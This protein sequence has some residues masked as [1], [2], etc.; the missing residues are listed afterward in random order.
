MI[1]RLSLIFLLTQAMLFGARSATAETLG[2]YSGGGNLA[3][4]V[5]PNGYYNIR[6]AAYAGFR[7]AVSEFT[8]G[9]VYRVQVKHHGGSWANVGNITN[10]AGTAFGF[11][12]SQ[13][14]V[15]A[16][17][18]I[19]IASGSQLYF[20]VSD[21]NGSVE[22][23]GTVAAVVTGGYGGNNAFYVDITR[24]T[25]TAR[26]DQYVKENQSS[27]TI[28]GVGY[29]TP[30]DAPSITIGGTAITA[31]SY[32]SDTQITLTIPA[33]DFG[34]DII[35]TDKALNTTS[36]GGL[37]MV[38]DNTAPTVTS[39]TP[40]TSLKSGGTTEIDGSGFLETTT[41]S[42][43]ASVTLGG[44]TTGIA[45]YN[46]D[47]NTGITVTATTGNVAYGFLT[48]TDASGNASSNQ[49]NAKIAIDN[50]APT[51]A[52]VKNAAGVN[53]TV[54]SAETNFN[55]VLLT[56]GS[57]ANEFNLANVAGNPVVTIGDK[58]LTEL[59]VTATY[60]DALITL[61]IGAT[62]TDIAD[63]PVKV[64]DVALNE[65]TA[66]VNF[67]IDRVKPTV[68]SIG[69]RYV[70][71]SVATVVNGTGF[72]TNGNATALSLGG[73]PIS[74]S[75]EGSWTPNS[76]TQ[77]T[78]TPNTT[79]FT[80]ANVTVTD[81]AG[82][83]S[84][85]T[86]KLVTVDNT[87]PVISQIDDNSAPYI[88][89]SGTQFQIKYTGSTAAERYTGGS[90]TSA[91]SGD[92]QIRINNAWPTGMTA[93]VATNAIT[94]TAGAGE[95]NGA[96]KIFDRSGN[97]VE[98]AGP[99]I[100]D[101][102]S[103]TVTDVTPDN[104]TGNGGADDD[105][106]HIKTGG[107]ITITGSDFQNG[108]ANSDVT[109]KLAS[110]NWT[111]Y[112]TVTVDNDGQITLANAEGGTASG[113]LVITDLAG[114]EL[115]AA[116]WTV[117]VDNTLP[118]VTK[119]E[120][121]AIIGGET[122][123]V[124]GTGFM[125]GAA[126][127]TV[128]VGGSNAASTTFTYVVDSN[129]Q[130]TITGGTGNIDDGQIIVTD[131]ATNASTSNVKMTID[132][133][134]P[135]VTE[136]ATASIKN[137][138]T[139]VI[140]GT[141]FRTT[142]DGAFESTGTA[143]TGAE[144]GTDIAVRVGG[145][146]PAG[147]TFKVNSATQITVTAGP[148]EAVEKLDV[149]VT[150]RAGNTSVETGKILTIDNTR[151][152]LANVSAISIKSSGTTVLTGE[153]FLVGGDLPANAVKIDGATPTGM[154]YGTVTSTSLVITAGAGNAEDKLITV[155]DAAGNVSQ[156]LVYL[157]IDNNLPTVNSVGTAAIR[158]GV[159]SV[160]GGNG[161]LNSTPNSD[162][163][164]DIQAVK[165]GE[166][167]ITGLTWATNSNTQ[168]TF[169]AGA[170]EV[171]NA[172]ITVR[173]F[174][175]NWSTSTGQNITIDNTPPVLTN[176]SDRWIRNGET[177]IITGS[178][179]K[180]FGGDA[181]AILI[182]GLDLA[183]AVNAGGLG[184][185][186]VVDSDTKITVTGGLGNVTRGVVHV[187]D[188]VGNWSDSIKELSIDNVAPA[189]PS[190]NYL[191]YS[192]S[193]TDGD[194]ISSDNNPWWYV[195]GVSIGDSIIVRFNK[196]GLVTDGVWLARPS[197]TSGT[198][199][200][201]WQERTAATMRRE[202]GTDYEDALMIQNGAPPLLTENGEYTLTA[203]AID[204]AGNESPASE[205]SIYDFDN[206]DP[207]IPVIDKITAETNTGEN[208]IDWVTSS[209]RPEFV[210]SNV[211]IGHRIALY[212]NDPDDDKS[213]KYLTL[214]D[215]TVR[216]VPDTIKVAEDLTHD[217]A[218]R[219]A[220]GVLF[221]EFRIDWS[222]RPVVYDIANNDAWAADQIIE[223]DQQ[224]D[225]AKIT[226]A[227]ITSGA[228]RNAVKSLDNAVDITVKFNDNMYSN[229]DK[230]SLNIYWP[231]DTD[232]PT[233]TNAEM[234]I[235]E[236]D[237]IWTYRLTLN[238]ED[239]K[240]QT[241]NVRV[242]PVAR[243]I[244]GNYID[245]VRIVDT[246]KLF[247]DNTPPDSSHMGT[248]TAGSR[249]DPPITIPV[250]W[251]SDDT[252]SLK[253]FL[254]LSSTD[255]TLLRGGEVKIE[256]SIRAK[257]GDT[258]RTV[259]NKDGDAVD[260]I[261]TVG[262]AVPF[263]RLEA[264]IL[265]SLEGTLNA[266]DTMSFRATV[267]DRSGNSTSGDPSTS[268]F[269][270]D[271]IPPVKPL[272]TNTFI[273]DTLFTQGAVANI[274]TVNRDTLWANDTIR[275]AFKSFQDKGLVTSD[276]VSGMSKYEYSLYQSTKLTP[277]DNN[278][279]DWTKFR[280]FRSK[281][282]VGG[283]LL[284]TTRT[285]T[286]AL[287]H[288]RKYYIAM[289]G[290]D[291]A[292]NASDTVNSFRTLRFSTRPYIAPLADTTAKED[293]LFEM[294]TLVNDNDALTLRGD[295]FTYGLTTIKI[296]TTKSPIDS[297]V[298]TNLT[299]DISNAGKLTFTPTK[300][301]TGY[302][303][304]RVIATDDWPLTAETRWENK[305]T[306]D[307]NI[308]VVP[309]NDA[310]KIDLSSIS[311]LEF[312]E[313]A[314]SDSINLTRYSYDEDNDTT[315][316]KF[317]FRIAS[318]MPSKGGFPTAK[319]GFL[320][321]FNAEYK[322]S[323]ISKLVDEFPSST[324]IQKNN[325][326]V[327]YPPNVEK[328][329]DPIKVYS[330]EKSDSVYSWIM[331]TDTASNDTNYYTS[332]DMIVEFTVTDPG[333]LTDEDTV[334]FFI[335]PINDPPVW[336]GLRDTIVKENDSLYID[337]ANYLTDV[338]DSTVTFSILPLTYDA[339]VTV[340]PT[341]TFEKKATGYVYSSD[342]RKDTVKF[343][344]SALWFD[345][346]SG[347]WNPIDPLSNQIKFQVS[348]ADGDTSAIDTFILR[349]QRVPRPEIRM[350]VVQNNAFTNYY[351]IF[352]V[353]SVGKTKDIALK[354]QSK[355]VTLDTAAA[356]TYVG[357]YNFKTKGT[358]TFEVEANGIVGDT[359]ITQNLGL[360]LAK[361]YGRWSG[362]S[363]DGQ[364]N[365][366]GQNGAVDF[367]QSIIIMDS[368]LFEP[369]FSDRASYLLGNEAFRF[370]KS[371]EISMPGQDNEMALYQRSTGTG[372]IELPSITQG[373]RIMAYTEK[374]G[375]F[376][377]GPKTLIVPGETALQ[378]NYPNPFNPVTTIAYDLGFI[379]GPFQ[380]VN[381]TV[382]DIL[383]R[384]VKTLINEQQGIGRYRVKWNGKDQN[385]VPV[386]SGIYFVHLLTDM[387]RSQTKKIMLM[388]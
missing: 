347:P 146:I 220:N 258:W 314:S 190:K 117:Y 18:G 20:Q 206:I 210:I 64:V 224:G 312:L 325:A 236:N 87:D 69:T 44:A 110:T 24:P 336:A 292:G 153:G 271:T 163:V 375:Y 141:G 363:A 378:Q 235:G 202:A 386:A 230:P 306:L 380:R 21:Y 222:Y 33:G 366:T 2:R 291:I 145:N 73:E 125:N 209:K 288:E 58:S 321:D 178:G 255:T 348:A 155:E 177:T 308:N 67:T 147:M 26:S 57:G 55:K 352:L 81:V 346:N 196:T 104:D 168:L 65:V 129:T 349:V 45:G 274:L 295:K 14:D 377:M 373:N 135:T 316:L 7:I 327:I 76:D 25:V 330:L 123:V 237:S 211:T 256:A 384:N 113:N 285:D 326:F 379:D 82:N 112:G 319:T 169:T 324:I 122:A 91:S 278:P 164:I 257:L 105:L 77:I 287:T 161:F 344:P 13:S 49:N 180:E 289:R 254:P 100:I 92:L 356:F 294:L 12:L 185:S 41:A 317:S 342:A 93:S 263:Y 338:D 266:G 101:N 80:D 223:I 371:V 361:M 166:N 150:D 201:D 158:S 279:A 262:V 83:T 194:Q 179:F 362:R 46:V 10:N 167:V 149:T 181:S 331:P 9:G 19:T 219:R 171:T 32:D 243:D 195:A 115:T 121:G 127:S 221:D 240:K 1:L 99:V 218:K 283:D 241:G 357:H 30:A 134:K 86:G 188:F 242:V 109:I 183:V 157:T 189:A 249:K 144:A 368:T 8:A 276:R 251:F 74:T 4:S 184:G 175:G 225:T 70:K 376:R 172:N 364:F 192:D 182:G 34:G 37:A 152:T 71:G 28:T 39:S 111:T 29:T 358:Y 299:A 88:F 284:D 174:A 253:F 50:T 382:Y 36:A 197:T 143:F 282:N 6:A 244:A 333:G 217:P 40:K 365:V 313:G 264:D 60:A 302:Y 208:S 381:M 75:G 343:K 78:F 43:I 307:L 269:V 229:P 120:P 216:T 138:S 84:A 52:S 309:V 108:V 213:G 275:F 53:I 370:K 119:V 66:G 273:R 372:W 233:I 140:T 212:S 27:V 267:Y 160:I 335:D 114:N 351:E 248:I 303:A 23:Q 350:Y 281:G 62:G 247:L 339:N 265:K 22:L 98:A 31:A 193:G 322:K 56:S 54:G 245:A 130:I 142:V 126:K 238:D 90:G 159:T 154:T 246:L 128:T 11:N 198:N 231:N 5:I 301:D 232:T 132:N 47:S 227:D 186:F 173:D 286:F 203:F 310:P 124:T 35:V 17:S 205:A 15:E 61:T 383:G 131:P 96:V 176:I 148:G 156:S 354:V 187:K 300:I 199:Q 89:K 360:A 165:L 334:T 290:V 340:E 214:D 318:T 59:G 16:A 250:G 311:K 103:P 387:G 3:A 293:I 332:Y 68:T 95:T 298:V 162:A 268:V 341:K 139:T 388:R 277:D 102:T 252:D 296:D 323:F 191:A 270:L 79:E 239:V 328:L 51:V 367:D 116:T 85:E 315:D 337:F 207:A 374:M 297:S 106:I 42:P 204:S 355:I 329:L 63:G 261:L 234:S 136:V 345:K 304:F 151:P 72:T 320:S 107:G 359:L 215:D 228:E 97:S 94:L 385:G 170:G 200:L 133:D 118:T 280:D 38:I 226:Y 369:Y 137:G 48:V 272:V 353:D 260:P 305:D 259:E